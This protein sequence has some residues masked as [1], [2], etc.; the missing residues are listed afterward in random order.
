MGFSSGASSAKRKAKKAA[1]QQYYKAFK[2]L[3]AVPEMDRVG[4]KNTRTLEESIGDNASFQ[5][6]RAVKQIDRMGRT[7]NKD[8][9]FKESVAMYN[10]RYNILKD[11]IN[12]KNSER[13][14]VADNPMP[15]FS[16]KDRA[17]KT[18]SFSYGLT[19]QGTQSPITSLGSYSKRAYSYLLIMWW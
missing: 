3:N 17:N 12:N 14:S 7:L 1:A 9:A 16:S 13:Y 10:D 5:T 4:T 19:G 2:K 11:Q 15:K 8:N 6:R 18:A